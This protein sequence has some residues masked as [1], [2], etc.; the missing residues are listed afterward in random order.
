MTTHHCPALL[1]TATGSGQGKTTVTAALARYHRN[2]GRRVRVFKAGPDFLDPMIHQQASGHPVHTLDMWMTGEEDARQRLYEAAGESDLILVEGVMGLFDGRPS[3]ADIAARFGI[4]VMPA[5][6]GAAMAQ[7]F[8]ALAHGL[9]TF[10][11]DVPFAGVLANRISGERHYGMLMECL[12]EHLI[13]FGYLPKSADA[14]LPSRHL[15]LV[16]AEEIADLDARLEAAAA[17]LVWK[18][19]GLPP[20][21]AFEPGHAAPVPRSLEGRR[22]AIARDQAFA[23]I[24]PANLELLERMGASLR[25]FSPVAGEGLPEAD[26]VYLP[27][28]YPEL[29]MEAL[30]ANAGLKRDLADHVQ[31]GRP[32]LAECGG[33]LYLLD[34]LEDKEGQGAEMAGLLT[35]TARMQGRL[36]SLGPQEVTLPEGVLRGHTFHHSAMESPL[37]PLARSRCPNGRATSEP[38][39]RVGG[40]TATYVHVYFP[41]NPEAVGRLLG[42]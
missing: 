29:H 16:Q 18:P 12:P 14:A 31:A 10:R 2:Q 11:S 40:M 20:P 13:A 7:T 39:Y 33:M 42:G 24:Y 23:F 4:P 19:E 32:L 34:R 36:A 15:G 30:A 28:G 35:G 17:Q 5:I 25:F 9:S 6:S 1:I 38:V 8:G 21:V 22:I 3:S 37:T 27:G 26:A 41:S